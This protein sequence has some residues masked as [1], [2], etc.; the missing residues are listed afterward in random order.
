MIAER[1]D[2]SIA[3]PWTSAHAAIRAPAEPFSNTA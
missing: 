2:E 3:A 1:Q